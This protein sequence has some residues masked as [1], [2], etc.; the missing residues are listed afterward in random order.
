MIAVP[1]KVMEHGP[2]LGTRLKQGL[3]GLWDAF[4]EDG[5]PNTSCNRR[6]TDSELH[7][8]IYGEVWFYILHSTS[9][10]DLISD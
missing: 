10:V 8:A 9:C 3:G 7:L 6:S 2:D 5:I 1:H 4:P